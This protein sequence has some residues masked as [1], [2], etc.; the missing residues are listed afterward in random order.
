MQEMWDGLWEPREGGGQA[1]SLVLFWGP[2]DGW[3]FP[4]RP[5]GISAP[6]PA[7]QSAPAPFP[8][9]LDSTGPQPTS[10]PLFQLWSGVR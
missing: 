10:L 8:L 2:L 3:D 5:L 7:F 6:S 1:Q 9:S 4:L